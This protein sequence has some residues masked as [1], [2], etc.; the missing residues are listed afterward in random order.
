MFFFFLS[1]CKSNTPFASVMMNLKQN[2]KRK[3]DC[4]IELFN[5]ILSILY[6]DKIGS[7]FKYNYWDSTEK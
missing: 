4:G 5:A 6:I 3:H 1:I 2:I 7:T